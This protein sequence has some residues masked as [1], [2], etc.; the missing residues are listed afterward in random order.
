MND[1]YK[2]HNLTD[3]QKRSLLV[4]AGLA[5][6][7]L[8]VGLAE[9]MES[10]P[11]TPS[12]T[13]SPAVPVTVTPIAEV[14]VPRPDPEPLARPH[15]DWAAARC[16]E[17]RRLAIDELR[18]VFTEARNRVPALVDEAKG[19][20][21]KILL[22]TSK[23]DGSADHTNFLK[24]K[25]Q[26]LVL[27][28]SDLKAAF[29]RSLS[30]YSKSIQSIEGELLVR[31]RSDWE[32]NADSTW[33]LPPDPGDL[34]PAFDDFALQTS[35]AVDADLANVV[36]REVASFVL[37]SLVE[38]VAVQGTMALGVLNSSD[39]RTW[40]QFGLELAAGWLFDQ[41]VLKPAYEAF[42]G[43]DTTMCD[44]IIDRLNAWEQALIE[45]DEKYAGWAAEL[46]G[47]AQR[48]AAWREE[49]LLDWLRNN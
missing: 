16:L 5:I 19:W 14:S 39:E 43:P 44:G 22:I 18:A 13:P 23:I 7:L 45:G 40:G 49:V 41:F 17:E 29:A 34:L 8:G 36:M 35:Q 31:L 32:E 47:H 2:W 20:S 37:S 48:R 27:S 38:R 26:S 9:V 12:V 25:F 4:A 15:L 6:T 24:D 3:R 11:A 21:S 1:N 42:V 10:R 30:I 33:T 46:T 28:E